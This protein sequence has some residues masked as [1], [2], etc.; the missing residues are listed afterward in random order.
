MARG[1][2]CLENKI[3][4]KKTT[5]LEAALFEM[6]VGMVQTAKR[7]TLDV[8]AAFLEEVIDACVLELYF[9][10]ECAA[11]KLRFMDQVSALLGGSRSGATVKAL[12]AFYSTANGS[13]HPIRNQ[14]LRLTAESPDLVAV[15][16]QEGR[17]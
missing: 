14:L 6:L 1:S 15:I 9:P 10:D 13:T 16:K 2:F 17:V 3:P 12:E 4:I 11:K 7:K 5:D 8:P